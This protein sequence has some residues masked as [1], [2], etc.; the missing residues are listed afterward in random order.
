MQ[1]AQETQREERPPRSAWESAAALSHAPTD[2]TPWLVAI[3]SAAPELG[4][5][6]GG[7]L[8]RTRCGCMTCPWPRHLSPWCQR[9]DQSWTA[10]CWG[11]VAWDLREQAQIL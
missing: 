11:D 8:G 3:G 2:W 1:E 10:G 7:L 9:C 5:D 6:A 4:Q